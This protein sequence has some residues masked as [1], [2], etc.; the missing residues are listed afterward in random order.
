MG[1]A[2]ADAVL[3]RKSQSH[4]AKAEPVLTSF[5]SVVRLSTGYGERVRVMMISQHAKKG[6]G[7]GYD[8]SLSPVTGSW[9]SIQ[10]QG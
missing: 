10:T 8:W 2:A 4:D 6:K 1:G 7:C 3:G 9:A 5:V